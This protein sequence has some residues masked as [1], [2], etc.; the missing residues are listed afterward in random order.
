MPKK[1]RQNL[2]DALG[3]IIGLSVSSVFLIFGKQEI[4]PVER[5][6]YPAL[7]SLLGLITSILM[8]FRHELKNGNH[9]DSL[10]MK[11]RKE[12]TKDND[13]DA[14]RKKQK[15][16]IGL[17]KETGEMLIELINNRIQGML[18]N[19]MTIE[20]HFDL[21]QSSYV[22]FWEILK[23]YRV[24]TKSDLHALATH[25]AS[26]EIW[27]DKKWNKAMYDY[28][29]T[30]IKSGHGRTNSVQ[31]IFLVDPKKPRKLYDDV[32]KEQGEH[33]IETFNLNKAEI[34]DQICPE[35]DFLI[36]PELKVIVEWA[37][38]ESGEL[39]KTIFSD[40]PSRYQE[41]LRDWNVL[42]EELEKI[43]QTGCYY[44]GD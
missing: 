34:E 8:R 25:K 20:E 3:V 1:R 5:F 44:I 18:A 2:I 14:V 35:V 39:F 10:I 40:N 6:F 21:H 38:G 9:W 24:N 27:K 33:G 15:E 32:I 17:I 36:I 28:Q 7:F 13:W 43:G 31:R 26:I 4:R 23:D 29:S 22:K 11:L 19:E 37:P 12:L 42:Q 41:R 30:F 16:R